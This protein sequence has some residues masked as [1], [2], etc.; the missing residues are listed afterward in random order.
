MEHFYNNKKI[1]Q[2]AKVLTFVFV[3]AF[4]KS[5]GQAILTFDF[6]GALG[7]EGS[8]PSSTNDPNISTSTITRSAALTAAANGDRF[9]STGFNTSAT[10]DLTQYIEFTV[11]P[12]AGYSISITSVVFL[13]QRSG[14]GPRT[15]ALRSSFDGYVSNLGGALAGA[16]VTTTQTFNFA[17][18]ALTPTCNVPIT[19][20]LYAYNSEATEAQVGRKMEVILQIRIL[21]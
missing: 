6:E 16:D 8:W 11:T 21:L 9:G 7:S 1:K 15:F 4:T 17:F 12:A 19:F 2:I 13:Y 3:F 18:S 10:I 14:T 5:W 20:R